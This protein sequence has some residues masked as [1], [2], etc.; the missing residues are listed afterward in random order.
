MKVRASPTPTP[1]LLFGLCR[2]RGLVGSSTSN[3][4]RCQAGGCGLH[5]RPHHSGRHTQVTVGQRKRFSVS[6]PLSWYH[7]RTCSRQAGQFGRGSGN[8]T[9]IYMFVSGKSPL[10]TWGGNTLARQGALT[11]E[12]GQHQRNTMFC[13]KFGKYL[14]L[15]R[16]LA[17]WFRTHGPPFTCRATLFL[18]ILIL[19]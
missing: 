7:L 2:V 9:K 6:L 1:G 19:T 10:T 12:G 14:V 17:I 11:S 8:P 16:N 3:V 18:F 4:S 13:L 15:G 5:G